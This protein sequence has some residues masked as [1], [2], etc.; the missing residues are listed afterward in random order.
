MILCVFLECIPQHVRQLHSS[1]VTNSFVEFGF[2]FEWILQADPRF[3]WFANAVPNTGNLTFDQ[4]YLLIGLSTHGEYN[5]QVQQE[6]YVS[7]FSF[8]FSDTLNGSYQD[9]PKV[10]NTLINMKLVQHLWFYYSTVGV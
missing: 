9:Y 6:R 4:T 5:F 2:S 3:W 7:S 1:D 10:I 8:K